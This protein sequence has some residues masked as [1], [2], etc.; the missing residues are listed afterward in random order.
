MSSE[1]GVVAAANLAVDFVPTNDRSPVFNPNSNRL[2]HS[3]VRMIR[4]DFS[5]PTGAAS[6]KSLNVVVPVAAWNLLSHHEHGMHS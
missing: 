6:T 4:I 2:N 1:E 5:K 3:L